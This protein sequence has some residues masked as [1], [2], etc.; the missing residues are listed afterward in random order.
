MGV[1]RRG[2]LGGLGGDGPP[3]ARPTQDARRPVGSYCLHTLGASERVP[4]APVVHSGTFCLKKHQAFH[5][6]P[7][8]RKR[9]ALLLLQSQ[10]RGQ[11]RAARNF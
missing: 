10:E 4:K 6:A 1:G 8:L 3:W 2:D 11:R 7:F 9:T 5:H